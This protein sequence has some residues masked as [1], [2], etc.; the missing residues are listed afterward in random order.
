MA[1]Y[2]KREPLK[3]TL[4]IPK[5]ET[6]IPKK[7]YRWKDRLRRVG[8]H[9]GR[10]FTPFRKCVK[11]REKNDAGWYP[12]LHNGINRRLEIEAWTNLMI[13]VT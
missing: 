10:N 13:F 4:Y 3:A 2:K 8:L 12:A 1:G 5:V 11:G 9:I 6:I 7:W